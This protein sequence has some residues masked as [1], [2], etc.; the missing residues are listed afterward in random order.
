MRDGPARP[1]ADGGRSTITFDH[2]V[3]GSGQATGTLVS[4]LPSDASVAVIEE[5]EVGGTCVNV[6]CTPTKTMVASARVAHMARRAG[7]YGV[8]TGEI[9]IDF[10]RVMERMNELRH[11]S[12]DGLAGMLEDK[13][14]VT[15]FRGRA[16]FEGPRVVSVGDARIEGTAVHL[17]V[18]AHPRVPEI[19]G[20]DRVPWLD[21]AGLLDVRELPEHLVVVG[22]SYVGLEFAQMFARFGS[23]VTILQSGPQ[24]LPR[25]DPDVAEAAQRIL[26]A[27]GIAIETDSPV[28]SVA[29]AGAGIAVEFGRESTRMTRGTHLLLAAGRVPN[30]DRLDLDAAGIRTDDR[31]YID[32]DDR[33][34]TSVEGVYAL[35]D[36]NGQGAFT[37]TSV[38]DA[39]IVLDALRGGTRRLS[40]RIP[41][42]AVFIDPPLGRVGMT[43]KEALAKGHR[44]MKAVRPMS[45]ISRAREMGET[46]GF[47][48]LLVDADDDMILGASILGVGGD[49]VINMFAA[50]MY[51]GQ[52]C[53]RYRRAVLVHPT[54]SE[55]MPWILDGL[56]PVG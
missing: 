54:V 10:A 21:N 45:S 9:G 19:S 48:K 40:D 8:T 33:L 13:S 35:G 2:V 5:G 38:N 7:E 49:E 41:T 36:V 24:I 46:Q 56:E 51:S 15:L 27:E 31:G 50:F 6:G 1:R 22:G 47:V 34:R 37:H 18:V 43:E 16:R 28:R 12:R 17:N 42:Y 11:G 55:L 23:R 14:N 44:V 39:E 52:P 4:G 29:P 20:L 30:S 25:E 32:V 53:H 3:V 26:E